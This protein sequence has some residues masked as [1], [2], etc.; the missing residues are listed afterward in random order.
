PLIIYIKDDY[1][2]STNILF[3]KSI[4]FKKPFFDF[5][6]FFATTDTNNKESENKSSLFSELQALIDTALAAGEELLEEYI[7]AIN[8]LEK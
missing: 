5:K 6:D 7:K 2:D 8:A 1:K 4:R 3:R